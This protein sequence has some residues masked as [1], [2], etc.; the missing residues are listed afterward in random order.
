MGLAV[1]SMAKSVSFQGAASEGEG[2]IMLTGI[3]TQVETE[4][5]EHDESERI[6]S[7]DFRRL[8]VSW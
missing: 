3:V 2:E 4:T 7:A 5:V 6:E 1:R 8:A